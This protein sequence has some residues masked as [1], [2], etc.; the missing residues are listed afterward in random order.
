[1]E[2]MQIRTGNIIYELESSKEEFLD[3]RSSKL[4]FKTLWGFSIK[5]LKDYNI[6][7]SPSK[8]TLFLSNDNEHVEIKTLEDNLVE[9][10]LEND[11]DNTDTFLYIN[12]DGMIL[13]DKNYYYCFM[14]DAQQLIKSVNDYKK[15]FLQNKDITESRIYEVDVDTY[16]I[17][18]YKNKDKDKYT[19]KIRKKK[20]PPSMEK[21]YTIVAHNIKELMGGMKNIFEMYRKY[22][23]AFLERQK[24]KKVQIKR[25]VQRRID[26]ILKILFYQ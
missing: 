14:G 12:N 8:A 21:T 2:Y 24:Q 22:F 1:M 11:K 23:T 9:G 15:D 26:V 3:R 7:I 25:K 5:D 19:I 4:R 13:N 16:I 17:K 18:I 10:Y 6:F 20:F